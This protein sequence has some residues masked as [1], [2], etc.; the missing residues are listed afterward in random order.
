MEFVE[1]AL[2]VEYS[3]EEER[4]DHILS[5]FREGYELIKEYQVVDFYERTHLLAEFKIKR[6][7][8]KGK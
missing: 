6:N 3:N 5:M 8:L 1:E 7:G 2:K 4:K